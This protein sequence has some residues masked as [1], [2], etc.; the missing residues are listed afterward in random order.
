MNAIDKHAREVKALD[1]RYKQVDAYV[2]GLGIHADLGTPLKASM[3]ASI[4]KELEARSVGLV[5]FILGEEHAK[6]EVEQK[7]AKLVA[8]LLK[9]IEEINAAQP[10]AIVVPANPTS[11]QLAALLKAYRDAQPAPTP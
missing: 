3:K 5:N 1:T 7:E 2:N 9:T 4:I 11:A 8:E 10:G 6:I